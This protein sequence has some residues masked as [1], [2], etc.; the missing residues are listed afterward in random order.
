VR[1]HL[2][3]GT[4]E[5]FRAHYAKRPGH[6]D[7]KG[8]ERKATVGVV[9]SMLRLLESDEKESPTHVAIAFDNPIESFRNELFPGYKTSDGVEPDLLA[10][11]DAVEDAAR[12][13]G[14]VVWRMD[15]WECD[16][17]L[18]TG[19]RKFRD[20]PDVTQVRICSPDKDLGQ[21]IVGTK[22]VQ[23]DRMREK[24]TDEAA[25]VE[26]RGFEPKSIPDFLALTGD[27][28]DGIPGVPGF[29]EVSAGTL[30]GQ[31]K[32]LEAIPSDPALWKVKVRGADRLALELSRHR[33]DARLY[34]K[35]A[36]LIDDVP[37]VKEELA[38]LE[39]KGV[40]RKAWDAWCDE[41]GAS[42]S[43]RQRPKKFR[44]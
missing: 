39:W 31:W 38:D 37:T 9:Y 8:R 18:A 33:D 7:P 26:A 40:P 35:L 10:Q 30:I 15:Q 17:G 22:V 24:E 23:L 1:V 42:E 34:K 13:I 6:R 14:M 36:T 5:L 19:A 44:A 20:H 32:T 12:A 3:D 27:T 28:A 43:L 21:C 41:V 11:F 2:V 29:G 4:W 16:D 25:L